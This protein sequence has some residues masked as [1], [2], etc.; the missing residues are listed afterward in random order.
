MAVSPEERERGREK[1]GIYT[2]DGNQNQISIAAALIPA[3]SSF[4]PSFSLSL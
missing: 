2:N 4:Q 3:I 1:T